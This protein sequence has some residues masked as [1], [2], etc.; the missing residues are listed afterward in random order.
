MFH[1]IHH[2][3]SSSV[4]PFAFFPLLLRYKSAEL[5]LDFSIMNFSDNPLMNFSQFFFSCPTLWRNW[6]TAHGLR[7]VSRS[8]N[9]CCN[10]NQI[11]LKI[12]WSVGNPQ[13]SRV[14]RSSRFQQPTSLAYPPHKHLPQIPTGFPIYCPKKAVCVGWH[15]KTGSVCVRPMSRSFLAKNI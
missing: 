2:L 13:R 15:S 4:F 10:I 3:H 7:K 8:S 11:A 1:M 12:S 14:P 9:F 6:L 5:F